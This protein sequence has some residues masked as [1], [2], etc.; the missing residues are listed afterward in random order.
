M[1]TRE[2]RTDDGRAD[3]GSVPDGE[4]SI[5]PLA[6]GVQYRPGLTGLRA[7]AVT[8]IVLAAAGHTW[9]PGGRVAGVEVL[10]VVS[11][12]LTVATVTAA[13]RPLRRADAA[14]AL[15]ARARRVLPAL[16]T[17]LGGVSLLVLAT[18]PDG[19]FRLGGEIR[20]TL[21]GIVN[22]QII[23]AADDAAAVPSSVEHLWPI[24]VG[25]QLTLVVVLSLMAA[26]TP[27]ARALVRLGAVVLA[28][29][30]AIAL[31]VLADGPQIA[32]RLR[33][34]TDTRATGLLLGAAMGLAVTPAR[35]GTV[36]GIR[37][38][39]LRT[40]GVLAVLGI[41]VTMW[42]GGE[43]AGWIGAGGPLLTDVLA[44]VA[45]AVIVRGAAA[46]PLMASGL[47]WLGLRSYAI[48]LWHWPV[49]VALGGPSAV[50]RPTTTAVYLL[51]VV[52]LGDVTYRFVEV[53]LGATW[54]V[55]G[56]R[57]A[58]RTGVAVGVAGLACGAACAAA[59]L[60]SAPFMP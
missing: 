47:Q 50:A 41:V 46:G 12:Y 42:V 38:R 11:G 8:G 23:M 43:G 10:F 28:V 13:D 51:S 2:D 29:A 5:A 21:L 58:G 54:R 16:L 44:V 1:T 57:T 48:Y 33:Y 40:V 59:L 39:R 49:I 17:L 32:D 19:L 52:I 6:G 56:S 60:T 31:S 4:A 15:A 20:A 30:S 26:A 35:H 53:P 24:A 55:E 45:V 37:G 27:R 7:V 14:R 18:R 34:G 22:W 25:A 9:I 3:E 36:T